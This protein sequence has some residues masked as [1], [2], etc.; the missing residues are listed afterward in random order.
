MTK[1]RQEMIHAMKLRNF[2]VKTQ[3]SYVYQIKKLASHYKK[4]PDRISH[5]ELQDYLIYMKEQLSL[6]FSSC[7]VARSAIRFLFGQVLNDKTIHMAIPAQRT[8]KYLPEVLSIE[9][10]MKLIDATTSFR[11]RML[12]M[13]AYSAG[14]RV[15]E[16]ISLKLEHIDSSRMVIRV[17]QGK[18]NK[19]RYTN[20][21]EVL[22]NELRHY[23]HVYRPTVWLFYSTRRDRPMS[24]STVQKIFSAAKRRAGITRGYG[25]HTLRHCFATH[26]VEAGYDIRHIQ[27]MMGHNH[28][29]TT[30]IYLHVSRESVSRIKS[31]LDIYYAN[32]TT[33]STS[34]E[35]GNDYIY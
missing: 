15:E 23:C 7:N 9:D 27:K 17:V 18:G 1:L 10:V 5:K 31:P 33:E 11:N 6:S 34:E 3:D 20:L 16:L 13:T 2:S 29:S 35:V 28:I 4:A 32:K 30:M 19:D 8:P 12:L 22:L 24:K 26:M 25:M 21:S 14:L